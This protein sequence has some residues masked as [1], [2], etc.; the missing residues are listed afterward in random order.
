MCYPVIKQN[1]SIVPNPEVIFGSLDKHLMY[2]KDLYEKA[3]IDIDR[4]IS[5][6]EYEALEKERHAQVKI[7]NQPKYAR[8]SD[9][10]R[11]EVRDND[12]PMVKDVLPNHA[13]KDLRESFPT[14]ADCVRV[15]KENA[16]YHTVAQFGRITRG[17]F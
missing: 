9:E 7:T 4:L 8:L 14:V 3:R 1:F 10:I 13:A 5:C 16:D 12:L 17:G 6:L 11:K 2:L 15:R